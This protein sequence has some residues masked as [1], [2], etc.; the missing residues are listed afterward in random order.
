MRPFE[1]AFDVLMADMERAERSRSQGV[2][3]VMAKLTGPYAES[4]DYLIA[5]GSW[6]DLVPRA[7]S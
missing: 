7:L 6:L 3:D 1:R 2:P 5:M 4:L